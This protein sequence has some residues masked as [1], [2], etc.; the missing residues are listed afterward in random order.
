[1]CIKSVGN[2]KCNNQHNWME[3]KNLY[4]HFI[5]QKIVYFDNEQ[6]IQASSKHCGESGHGH[7]LDFYPSGSM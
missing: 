1:M 7:D 6:D 3:K 5:T 2:S 4:D